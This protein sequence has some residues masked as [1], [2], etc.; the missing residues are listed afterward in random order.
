MENDDFEIDITVIAKRPSGQVVIVLGPMDAADVANVIDHIA[1]HRDE[2]RTE[3]VEHIAD[4]LLGP[5][6]VAL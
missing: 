5:G 6:W 1:D 4:T 2:F 3:L